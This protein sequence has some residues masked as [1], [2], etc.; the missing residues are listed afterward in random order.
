VSWAAVIGGAFV[1]AALSL[2]LLALGTGLGFAS[3]SP[4]SNAGV[5]AG[6]IG[7][8]A[9]VW[10]IVM[11]ILA[12]S[13]GG[14][15][16]GRLRTK[17]ASI[18]SDE[19][20]FRDTAHGFLAWAVAMVISAAFLTS[21][22]ATMVGGTVSA[23]ANASNS[24]TAN[25][26]GARVFDPNQYFVD[27]LFRPDGAANASLVGSS[28]TGNSPIGS[29]AIAILGA[30]NPASVHAQGEASLIFANALRQG[31]MPDADQT[32]LA[33]LISVQT[34]ITQTDAAKRVLVVLAQ[35]QLAA[36]A[37]RKE[38]AHASI[39]IFVALL[40]GAFSASLAATFGGRQRDNVVVV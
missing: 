35:A 31:S 19:V 16:A 1:A 38:I 10:F 28:P 11:Q 30:G 22:A 4:W 36:D 18:H 2:I 27:L 14:Y 9:I 15:L 37:V 21:A 33:Q 12:S 40:F 5:H 17:W 7:G 25:A 26:P 23:A 29:S 24:A 34:G 6:T 8:A 32:Y 20:Y 13:M 3:V 39:W